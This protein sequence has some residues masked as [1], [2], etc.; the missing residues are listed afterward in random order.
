MFGR[1]DSLRRLMP[2]HEVA[3]Q[4]LQGQEVQENEINRLPLLRSF[5]DLTQRFR[6][7]NR[8]TGTRGFESLQQEQ[9][10]L[11][12]ARKH[13]K[14]TRGEA[15]ELCRISPRQASRLLASIAKEN[16]DLVL[17]GERTRKSPT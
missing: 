12:Y 9:M 15:A 3:W 7:R 5:E 1:E 13:G 4:V 11:Q 6:A 8:S 17:E 2:T 16:S 14:I 10:V